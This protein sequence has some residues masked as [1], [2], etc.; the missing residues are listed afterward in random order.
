MT[1]QQLL[2]NRGSG[3]YLLELKRDLLVQ[4]PR[5]LPLLLSRINLESNQFH[6]PEKT[7]FLGILLRFTSPFD[8][9]IYT[10]VSNLLCISLYSTSPIKIANM[11]IITITGKLKRLIMNDFYYGIFT[12][13]DTFRSMDKS[14]YSFKLNQGETSSTLYER[15]RPPPLN[16]GP[17]RSIS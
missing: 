5:Y 16:L 3:G 15:S 17:K 8:L 14:N 4:L 7:S 1:T 12:Y 2:L 10:F 13:L 9:C 11:V 6:I